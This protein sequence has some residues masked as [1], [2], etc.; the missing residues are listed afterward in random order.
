MGKALAS[1]QQ[2]RRPAVSDPARSRDSA[3]GEPPAKA[4]VGAGAGRVLVFVPT[5]ND[6][7]HLSEIAARVFETL[8]EATLLLIDDG[9]D[10]PIAAPAPPPRCLKVRLAENFGVGACTHIAFDHV[11]R[12]GYR[13]VVR[14]DADGQHPA[15]EIPRLLER[16]TEHGAD[17]V[18][19]SR[20]NQNMGS[21][22]RARLARWAKAYMALLSRLLTGGAAPRDVS[23]GFFAA[24]RRA[25]ETLNG[26]SLHRY[27][28]PQLFT[29]ACRTGLVTE[30]VPIE[31]V[32][33]D[34]GKSTVT[35]PQ[36]LRILYRFN[37]F[38]VNELMRGRQ[39]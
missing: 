26:F 10:R 35:L 24:S 12:H 27:P 6:V 33:R 17:L 37:V 28:E 20:I 2:Q 38:V 3:G 39:G 34:H 21:G 18:A 11:L 19:G 22:I 25:V 14:L 16:V 15:R 8:P 32:A 4:V 13:A 36:A 30:E 1:R 23:T 29:L 5:Y 9:S 7:V 31:Q